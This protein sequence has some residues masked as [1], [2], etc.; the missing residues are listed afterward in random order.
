MA[1]AGHIDERHDPLTQPQQ[2]AA[3]GRGLALGMPEIF[4][5]RPGLIQVPPCALVH[6]A[7]HAGLFL[8]VVALI[9]ETLE[10]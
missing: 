6:H 9:I 2:S 4:F 7:G 8:P 10:A 1:D 3:V 5:R